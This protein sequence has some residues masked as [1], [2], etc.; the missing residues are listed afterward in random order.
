[1]TNLLAVRF[2]GAILKT[3]GQKMKY[4][5]VHLR[6]SAMV[7][8]FLRDQWGSCASLE[9]AAATVVKRLAPL[10][11]G[12]TARFAAQSYIY[13][14]PLWLK[15]CILAG[16]LLI[17]VLFF[18]PA[19]AVLWAE[20][21][22]LPLWLLSGIFIFLDYTLPFTSLLPPFPARHWKRD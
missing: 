16:A 20:C 2:H 1:M 17:I 21:K 14:N 8:S 13:P 12:L 7:S 4:A 5:S 15:Y 3:L 6:S 9:L 18:H 11:Q 10:L 19:S 22:G